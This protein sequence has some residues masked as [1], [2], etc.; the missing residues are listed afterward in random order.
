[1]SFTMSFKSGVKAEGVKDGES[2]DEDCN[3]AVS[4]G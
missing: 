3:E 1:M 2:E 4:A